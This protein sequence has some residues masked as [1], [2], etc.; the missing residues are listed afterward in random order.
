MYARF[1]VGASALL[2]A[3][4]GCRNEP[5][6]PAPP[7]LAGAPNPAVAAA[8][9]PESVTVFVAG[10]IHAA[11]KLYNKAN[12]TAPIVERV[13]SAQVIVLGDNAG[14]H[15]TA[16]EYQC[17]DLTWGKFKSRTYAVIGNHELNQDP[18]ATAYYDYFNGVGVDSGVA[19]LR[20]KGYY[21]LEL[22]G[23]HILVAN[24]HQRYDEQTAWMTRDLAANTKR[25]TMAIWH[26]PLFTS[27]AD[28][29]PFG[30]IKPWWKVLYGKV[31]VVLG[32][33]AHEYERFAEIRPDGVVD[34]AR[35]IREFVVGTGGGF[36]MHFTDPP[37]PA[38]QK[39][40]STYGVLKLT[41]WPTRYR[42][43]FI[44]FNNAVLDSGKDTCH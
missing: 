33:H 29:P 41:L 15:G 38:S 6:S 40:I 42:W 32:G 30:R 31:D 12:L 25:C 27:S 13:P 14:I 7:E 23:W 5:T 16:A 21:T 17:Y 10:D 37:H 3:A 1:L 9:T 2:L 24:S 39:R 22:G 20:G 43:Q 34:T 36:L 11:C 44:D 28:V 35:G 26:S 8:V 19:G 4:L 18:T